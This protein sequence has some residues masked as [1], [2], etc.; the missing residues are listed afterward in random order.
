MWRVTS[1]FAALTL[2]SSVAAAQQ[3]CTT[4]ANRV[5]SEVYRHVLERGVDA[6]AQTWVRQLANGQINVRELVRRVATSQEYMQRF[7]QTEAGERQP[8]ERAVASLYRHI[9]G[10]QPD[11]NG[12]RTW[13]NVAQQRGLTAVVDGFV[14][15]AEYN[16]NFGDWG[17]PGSGGLRF[18]A[19][20]ANNSNTSSSAQPLDNQRFRAMDANRDGVIARRE[21]QGSNQ[22]F[23]VHDWNNDGVLSGDEV[24]TG[25][26][27]QG[28]NAD[29]EDYDRAED[30]EFL[31]ANNNNR[32][33]P[34][35]WHMSPRTF[36]LLD[37][38]NDGFVSRAEFA[39]GNAAAGTAATAGQTVAVAADRQWSDTGINVRAGETI[40]INADGRIRLARDT[41]D[42]VTAAGADGR[43]ADATMP[44]API[45]GLVARFG[46]SA[47][48]FVGQGRTFRAPRAGRLYLGV[49]DSYFDDNTGQFNVRV[50]VD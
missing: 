24:V 4:D 45:G 33:E 19:N 39:R 48:V 43:V 12:Q 40:T 13:T 17:I 28:R 16:N 20:N 35:E 9:L 37:R 22:S 47:P 26:F 3:P 21:W 31:D 2:V 6:G 7:G 25:R 32:I 38:N 1:I 27:R 50:D 14:G 30:F 10:R 5:V 11:D 29:F 15:A 44:N 18:C 46:D 34:R 41:R 36:E 23:R 42:F 49:N 8:Y